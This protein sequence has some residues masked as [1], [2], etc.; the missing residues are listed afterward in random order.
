MSGPPI[1]FRKGFSVALNPLEAAKK[2]DVCQILRID[3]QTFT[4]ALHAAKALQGVELFVPPHFEPAPDRLKV[5]Q[6]RDVAQAL[7]VPDLDVEAHR[8]QALETL[9]RLER[10]AAADLQITANGGQALHAPQGWHGRSHQLQAAPHLSEARQGCQR[11][12]VRAPDHEAAPVDA[13]IRPHCAAQRFDGRVVQKEPVQLLG[14]H[15]RQQVVLERPPAARRLAPVPP[16]RRRRREPEL[17]LA[18]DLAA[19]GL[20]ER[21]PA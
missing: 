21:V 16:R 5:Q 10:I 12:H 3:H 1:I 9:Q 7:V 20:R 19:A 2:S 13:A 15:P 11:R 6:R 17:G 18:V 4:D 14:L 8:V